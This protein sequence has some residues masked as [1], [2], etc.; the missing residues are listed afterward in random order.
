MLSAEPGVRLDP[1]TLGLWPEWN[2][3]LDAH[4]TKPPMCPWIGFL[5]TL[6]VT[7]HLSN[8]SFV[9]PYWF[10]L[11]AL[12]WKC[13]FPVCG[14]LSHALHYAIWWPFWFI[15]L[16]VQCFSVSFS[17]NFSLPQSHEDGSILSFRSYIFSVTFCICF[18][19]VIFFVWMCLIWL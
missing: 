17:R 2:Q 10:V 15:S 5:N 16:Y 11:W 14:F 3:E 7:I 19:T 4:W 8:K 9:F 6:Q 13:L 18:P 12:F 1:M